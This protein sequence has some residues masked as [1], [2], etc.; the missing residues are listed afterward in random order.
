[1][2]A[3]V[4]IG[5]GLEPGLKDGSEGLRLGRDHD[6]AQ[7]VHVGR[8]TLGAAG[9][10][11]RRETGDGLCRIFCLDQVD[12]QPTANGDPPARAR[13]SRQGHL[14]LLDA[15]ENLGWAGTAQVLA[16]QALDGIPPGHG[17]GRM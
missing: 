9:R 1:V 17:Q 15:V 6:E 16:Y 2:D 10:D 14:T 3:F 4:P 7:A 11:P 5:Q 13:A 8:V 12:Q